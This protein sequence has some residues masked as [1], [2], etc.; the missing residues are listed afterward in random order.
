MAGWLTGTVG[1]NNRKGKRIEAHGEFQILPPSHGNKRV[2]VLFRSD[3]DM[4]V[5]VWD[6][7]VVRAWTIAEDLDQFD[8]AV[9]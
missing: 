9:L 7:R 2:D 5:G 8:L 3:A 1:W 6:V 4:A